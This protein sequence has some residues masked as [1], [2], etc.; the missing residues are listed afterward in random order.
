[1]KENGVDVVFNNEDLQYQLES[2][3]GF[4]VIIANQ[5][6]EFLDILQN[7]LKP[8]GRLIILGASNLI[9]NETL[10]YVNLIK[11]WWNTKKI[12]PLDLIMKN[13]VVAGLNLATLIETDADK[14]KE[15][16]AKIFE[17]L[18]DGKIKP[19]IH[20]VWPIEKFVDATK[21]LAERR[22]VGKVLISM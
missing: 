1:M 17:L 4:D 15:V 10:S 14:I 19:K 16:F 6:G 3:G 18:K 8:L 20:S 9:K 5:A 12:N 7:A 22:N 21:E 2:S 11:F 13:R